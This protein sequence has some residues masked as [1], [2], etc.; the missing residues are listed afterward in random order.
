[1]SAAIKDPVVSVCIANYNGITIISSCL[2]SIYS[3]EGNIPVEIIVHDDASTDG[4]VDFLRQH[5][6]NINLIPSITNVGFCIANNRMAEVAK[7]EYLLLLNN[8]ATLFPDALKALLCRA[9]EIDSP[10]ILGLPQY[11]ADNGQLLDRGSLLDPFLNPIPNLDPQRTEVGMIMGA[12]LWI[13]KK[14]WVELGGFPDWFGSIAE[15]LYLCCR[16]RLGNY[17]VEVLRLSGYYHKVGASFGGGKAKNGQL[18]TT[19]KRRTLSEQ[20]KTFT[21]MACYPLWLLIVLLPIHLTLLCLEG[22]LLALIKQDMML[23]RQV[24][25]SVFRTIWTYRQKVLL[26]RYQTQKNSSSDMK[27]FFAPFKWKPQ[28]LRMLIKFKFPKIS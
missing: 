20:N 7:G 3:Q 23:W 14:L 11:D 10:A 17:R 16:A 15:D 22:G 24:Y 6:P 18:I 25:V 4:S 5:F 27:S 21:M 12:C 2:E 9:R 19:Y 28:K 8:D 26:L 1:M 13:P